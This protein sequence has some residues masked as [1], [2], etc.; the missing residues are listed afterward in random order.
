MSRLAILLFSLACLA[1]ATAHAGMPDAR[2]A[3]L[4]EGTDFAYAEAL[5]ALAADGWRHVSDLRREGDFVRATA[6]DFDGRR[7][8]V[9]VDPRTGVVLPEFETTSG[10]G[11]RS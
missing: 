10:D 6:E 11:Q 3:N 8:T 9:L 1:T 7:R 2:N 5:N 4:G